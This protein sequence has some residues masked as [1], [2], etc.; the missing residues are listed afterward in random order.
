MVEILTDHKSPEI[1]GTSPNL[2]KA[3]SYDRR[4]KLLTLIR[5]YM[6]NDSLTHEE[7]RKSRLD[8]LPK[9]GDSH[10]L[11]NWRYINFLDA[12]SKIT[13]IILNRRAQ[14]ISKMNGHPMQFGTNLKF[15]FLEAVFSLKNLL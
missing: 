4:S 3:L 2:L 12:S 8:P 9:I 11:N 5:K 1:N 15:D 6:E 7:R 13:S 10:D 14:L